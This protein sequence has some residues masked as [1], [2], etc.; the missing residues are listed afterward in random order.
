MQDSS[1]DEMIYY[2]YLNNNH[3]RNIQCSEDEISS[4]EAPCTELNPRGDELNKSSK[5]VIYADKTIEL[6]YISDTQKNIVRDPSNL[7][8]INGCAGS[9]KT[10]T[11]IKCG[12]YNMTTKEHNL[13][14]LTLVSSVTDEIM[15]RITNDYQIEMVRLNGSNHFVGNYFGNQIE[16]ANFDAWTYHQMLSMDPVQ[17]DKVK[18][19]HSKRISLLIELAKKQKYGIFH[20]KQGCQAQCILI[21]EFQDFSSK[22]V[23]LLKEICSHGSD[24]SIFVV[25]DVL[26][27]L[28]Q[29]SLLDEMSSGESVKHNNLF[30]THNLPE[31]LLSQQTHIPNSH[32]MNRFKELNPK[33]F[34]LDVCYRCPKAHIIF[35]NLL[36][37]GFQKKYGVQSLKPNNDDEINKPLIFTHHSIT[38]NHSAKFI[39]Y[40]V[41][42]I[43]KLLFE[44]EGDL[45]QP[46]DI[47][48]IMPKSNE[49]AVYEHLKYDLDLFYQSIKYCNAV[50]HFATKGESERITINWKDAEGKT[51]LLSIHGDKGR[52]H[53]VVILLG[54]TKGSLPRAEHKNKVSEL[55]D[56]SLLNVGLTRSTQ[57]LFIGINRNAPSSYLNPFLLK[58]D[59]K[60]R[61]EAYMS[62]NLSQIPNAGGNIYRAIAQKVCAIQKKLS[63]NTGPLNIKDMV[64]EEHTLKITEIST[65]IESLNDIYDEFTLNE[66]VF[67]TRTQIKEHLNHDTMSIIGYMGELMIIRKSNKEYFDQ[68]IK[69]YSSD[70]NIYYTDNE[71]IISLAVDY[72]LNEYF[73]QDQDRY[74]MRIILMLTNNSEYFLHHEAN[75]KVFENLQK[76]PK[77]VVGSLFNYVNFKMQLLELLSDKENEKIKTNDWWNVTL[78]WND[79]RN[80]IRQP[81]LY[82]YMDRLNENIIGIHLNVNK[83]IQ[84]VS[85][86]LAFQGSHHLFIK[87]YQQNGGKIRNKQIRISGLSDI[88]DRTNETLIEI[89]MSHHTQVLNEWIIQTLLYY[90]IKGDNVRRRPKSLQIVNLITGKLYEF[91]PELSLE[92]ASGIIGKIIA[93]VDLECGSDEGLLNEFIKGYKKRYEDYFIE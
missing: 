1:S 18:G 14:F 76:S 70:D 49:N 69:F 87:M 4:D 11:L 16:V 62:W 27:T 83:Y 79:I 23:E 42:E 88:Y 33:R 30:N 13:L 8:L 61:T 44:L 25:G 38:E 32:P 43:I 92:T 68:T 26:Q 55:I 3:C 10:D 63:N 47:A 21:D 2:S 45:L 9:R 39:S 52:G 59:F 56:H 29:R 31:K 75:K 5:N 67:G 6:N 19:E 77:L 50:K 91:V 36:M 93:K 81:A 46:E 82:T 80:K 78:F 54:V 24:L 90:L 58:K 12:I 20:M 73:L 65:Q 48:I 60:Q 74:S 89:K 51:T 85:N 84:L 34:E 35:A 41:V 15:K 53:K 66:K 37:E 71:E 28:F 64:P 7:K 40:Q 72:R 17:L 86:N 57:Y 22:C